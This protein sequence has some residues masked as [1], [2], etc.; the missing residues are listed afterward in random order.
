MNHRIKA[1][2]LSAS[3]LV[4]E[5]QRKSLLRLFKKRL[6]SRYGL[7][8]SRLCIGQW[9]RHGRRDSPALGLCTD[10]ACY[11]QG[12]T[13][14]GGTPWQSPHLTPFQLAQLCIGKAESLVGKDG[15]GAAVDWSC[16]APVVPS[17]SRL[18]PNLPSSLS[19]RKALQLRRLV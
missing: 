12:Q 13:P 15:A 8:Y 6:G 17:S 19:E 10:T 9:G 5:M 2:F 7:C 1:F 3:R 11:K 18:A 4:G 16:L 14:D